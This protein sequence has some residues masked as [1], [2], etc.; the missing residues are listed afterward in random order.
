MTVRQKIEE[1][2]EDGEKESSSFDLLLIG[3][4]V[5]FVGFAEGE[6]GAPLL[7]H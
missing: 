4:E 6:T 2:S 3:C 7:L 5:A 1:E